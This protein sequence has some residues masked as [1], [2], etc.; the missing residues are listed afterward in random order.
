MSS[1]SWKLCAS[2]VAM[3]VLGWACDQ[4]FDSEA[5][6]TDVEATSPT[7]VVSAAARGETTK[8]T[9]KGFVEN[10]E[11]LT[12][13]NRDFRRVVY[14]AQHLQLVLMSIPAGEHIGA[15]THDVDQFFRIEAG[16]GQIVIDGK[17]SDVGPGSAMLVPAGARHDVVASDGEELKLYTLYAPPNHRDGVVHPT[18][19]DAERDDEKFDGRTTE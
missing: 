1:S 12:E 6:R 5:T 19:A 3:T 17:R 11:T 16:T 9:R 14:T 15:E 13:R 7:T 4:R 10:I 2:V 8:A 18:R